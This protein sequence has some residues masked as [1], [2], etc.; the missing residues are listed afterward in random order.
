MIFFA[1]ALALAN[2][3][4]MPSQLVQAS[5]DVADFQED[6]RTRWQEMRAA[7]R[8]GDAAGAGRRGGRGGRGDAAGQQQLP[9]GSELIRYGSSADQR[10]HIWPAP[11]SATT[12]GRRPPLAVYIHGGGWQHGTP[13]MV[14]EKPQWFAAHGWA[15][16][17][18]GYRLVPDATVEDEAADI[19]AALRRLRTEAARLGYDP[20]RILLMGHSAGAHLTA[21]VATDPT[22]A[23]NAFA[24]IRGAM[25]IDGAC[26]DVPRQMQEGGNFMMQRTYVPAFGTDV[27]RQRALSPTT[28]AGGPDAPAWLILFDSGRDDAVSQSGYLSDALRRG[29]VSVETQGIRFDDRNVLQRHRKMNVEF[30]TPGYAGNAVAEALMRRVEDTR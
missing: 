23:G 2:P 11:A 9:P 29:G 28:H 12:G 26:Y 24:A 20:D 21:L 30:G 4:S 6:R 19:G 1:L 7:R 17:S 14:A 10:L 18:V 22:Y 5:A 13:E 3:N 15:F 27:A 8:G 25:P 16:A